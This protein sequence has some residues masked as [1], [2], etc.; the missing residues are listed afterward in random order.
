[1]G[2]GQTQ[3][4]CITAGFWSAD[5]VECLLQKCKMNES[6]LKWWSITNCKIL[7]C[8]WCR[9]YA[10]FSFFFLFISF[11]FFLWRSL[12]CCARLVLVGLLHAFCPLRFTPY[13]LPSRH[14]PLHTCNLLSI[15]KKENKTIKIS[16]S[17]LHTHTQA[18]TALMNFQRDIGF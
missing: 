1:M 8:V 14:R 10:C 6:I 13:S 15:S 17:H 16:F 2:K 12:I 5:G 3:L 9:V 4:R 7:F 18:H 11:F